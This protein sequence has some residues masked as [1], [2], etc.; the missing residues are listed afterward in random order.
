MASSL[1][2]LA[3]QN[4]VV[5]K[6]TVEVLDDRTGPHRVL[7]HMPYRLTQGRKPATEF[8]SQGRFGL[9]IPR[10]P[11]IVHVQVEHGSNHR[12]GNLERRGQTVHLL[13]QVGGEG[14]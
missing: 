11:W 13:L 8:A 12:H 2:Q 4:E 5:A 14:P 10:S 7:G 9:P 3:A 6:P 1:A